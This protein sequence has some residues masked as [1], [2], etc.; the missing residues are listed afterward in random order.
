MLAMYCKSK[1]HGYTPAT[2]SPHNGETFEVGVVSE[3]QSAQL[4]RDVC[5]PLLC[6]KLLSGTWSRE[7]VFGLI[8]LVLR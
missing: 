2:C 3:T 1:W 6:I 4:L 5:V 8:I 7:T